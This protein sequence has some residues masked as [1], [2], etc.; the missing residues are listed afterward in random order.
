MGG[1]VEVK[2]GLRIAYSNQKLTILETRPASSE[3]E[4]FLGEIV[5]S[6]DPSSS[7][8][9]LQEFFAWDEINLQNALIL[10]KMSPLSERF[11]T[12]IT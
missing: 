4:H 5:S 10:Q 9:V 12:T 3:I 2:A 11:N 7:R 8:A 1:W 6:W